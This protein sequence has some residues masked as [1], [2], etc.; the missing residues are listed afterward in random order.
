MNAAVM[1]MEQEG[2]RSKMT[3]DVQ[4]LLSV[5][6]NWE[7]SVEERVA[8]TERLGDLGAAGA[9]VP[10]TAL[11]GETAGELADVIAAALAKLSAVEIML[12]NLKAPTA[13]IRETAAHLL[14]VLK[15]ESSVPGLIS[16]L[17]DSNARVRE[18]VA[19]ALY[20]LKDARAVPALEKVLFEDDDPDVRGAAAQALGEL[21]TPQA[22]EALERAEQQEED[23]FTLI[24]I[25][26][27]VRRFSDQ[28]YE[29]AA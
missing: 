22:L 11:L 26:R 13:D 19:T 8:A 14:T 20:E 4:E 21:P 3:N 15:D 24:L 7:H 16:A 12:R 9:V 6:L 25:E 17:A 10:L 23:E 2:K 1:S 27:S 5:A 29:G 28:V 18:E